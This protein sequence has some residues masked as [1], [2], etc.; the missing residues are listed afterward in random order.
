[1]SLIL[2]N[3]PSL[4][5]RFAVGCHDIEWKNKKAANLHNS[6][7]SA[8]SVLMRL[9]YP[10]RVKKGDT[11]ANWITHSQYAKALCDIA[12]LPAFLSNWLSGLASIKKTRFYMDA[13]I[14]DDQQEPFPVIVFSHGLGGNRLIYSSICADLASHGFVVVAIEHRDGSASLA[15]GIDDEWIQYDNVPPEI[16]GFRHHQLRHRVSEVDLCLAALDEIALKGLNDANAPHFK[17]KLDMNSLVMA[18]HSFGGATTMLTLNERNTR[19]QCGVLLDPW[20]QPLM[21]MVDKHVQIK[22]PV[23]AIL[24]E[25]F[26]FW[27]DNFE[28]VKELIDNSTCSNESICLTLNGTEHQHQSDVLLVLR[29][30]TIFDFRSP[31]QIDPVRAIDLNTEAAVTFINKCIKSTTC[32]NNKKRKNSSSAAVNSNTTNF[33]FTRVIKKSKL[34]A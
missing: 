23:V 6:E 24:S 30:F 16:W 1:M 14:L 22:K 25:Q 28:S 2:A 33:G 9:Y 29:Y 13:D 12:K 32:R 8:K 20:A 15:K 7:P 4:T 17:G 19:F 11:R 21:M 18:G 26:T 34:A 31:F 27:P 10:A 5:G 3:F